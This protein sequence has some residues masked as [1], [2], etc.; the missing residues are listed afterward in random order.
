MNPAAAVPHVRVIGETAELPNGQ[1]EESPI[2]RGSS[3]ERVTSAAGGEP[4][5]VARP[6]EHRLHAVP[7]DQPLGSGLFRVPSEE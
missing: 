5:E 3:L 1:R 4:D 7:I 2:A 6:S